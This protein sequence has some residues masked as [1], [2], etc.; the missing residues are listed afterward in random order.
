MP[1]PEAKALSG[2][3]AKIAFKPKGPETKKKEKQFL[4]FSDSRSEAAFFAN[5]LEKS[6]E[7]FL[8]RRGIWQVAKD[9]Q[10]HGEYALSVPAFV[11]RLARVFEKEQ[12][13]LL[14]K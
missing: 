7:E 3:F 8:R 5:Y 6:Y 2:P 4:C 9:M 13:F 14:W 12:S 1:Q 10:A 11:D